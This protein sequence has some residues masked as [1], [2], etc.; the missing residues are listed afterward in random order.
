MILTHITKDVKAISADREESIK[1]VEVETI[2][3]VPIYNPDDRA[4]VAIKNSIS[5][6]Q[7]FKSL[8][9]LYNFIGLDNLGIKSLAG[10]KQK[11]IALEILCQ[12]IDLQEIE[13]KKR[14]RRVTGIYE[15]PHIIEREERRGKSGFYIDRIV[16]IMVN[17]LSHDIDKKVF[18]SNVNE[19]SKI[20]GIVGRNFKSISCEQLAEINPKFTHAMINQ[21]YY[22][23]RREQEEVVFR[24]LNKLQRNYDAISYHKNFCIVTQ[25]EEMHTSSINE[26]TIISKTQKEVLDKFNVK[27]ISTI[28][29]K[30]QEKQ[31]FTEVCKLINE[32]YGLHWIRYY[33]QIQIFINSEELQKIAHLFILDEITLQKNKAEVAQ[34]FIKRIENRTLKDIQNTNLKADKEIAEW[35]LKFKELEISKWVDLGFDYTKEIN[36]MKPKPYKFHDNYIKIQRQLMAILLGVS[37]E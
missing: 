18:F 32:K 30:R 3:G 13:G 2:S 34:R 14:A 25:R 11:Q 27:C 28:Y 22:R 7:I 24:V 35:E 8:K 9:E 20:M 4:E 17:Y 19:L 37:Q 16:P 33:P 1:E 15:V 12:Y 23:C 26:D 10:G 29:L 6:G 21:F 31:F 36:K 5:I